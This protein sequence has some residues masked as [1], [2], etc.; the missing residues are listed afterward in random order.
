MVATILGIT[1]GI[2]SGKSSVSRLLSCYCLA[3]LIDLD[4]C[5]RHLLDYGQL[6]WQALHAAF[7]A[8]Y[9]LADGS[10]DRRKLREEIFRDADVRRRVDSLLH[11]LAL[12]LMHEQIE[13]VQHRAPLVLVEIPL[14]YEAGWQIQVDAVLVVYARRAVQCC[15]LM[16]RDGVD[17]QQARRSLSAQMNLAEKARMAD[18]VI[19]NSG[20]WLETRK[21]VV[22][23][24]DTLCSTQEATN[25]K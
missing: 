7:G 4:Q 21:A 9:A 23:L 8:T 3:P 10:I 5:C 19:D 20:S 14:L 11:P 1:G 17:R 18:Y 25:I 16:R 6:G 12:G 22:A 13:A 2:G 15:R 24:G